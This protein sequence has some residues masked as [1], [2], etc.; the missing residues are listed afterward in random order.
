MSVMNPNNTLEVLAAPASLSRKWHAL[1]GLTL[2]GI[3][4]VVPLPCAC[5]SSMTSCGDFRLSMDRMSS[6]CPPSYSTRLSRFMKDTL[7][8]QHSASYSLIISSIEFPGLPYSPVLT[9]IAESNE[10]ARLAKSF[11]YYNKHGE[12]C[13]QGHH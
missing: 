13:V 8:Q 12:E 2:T 7:L 11:K 9:E 5:L 3:V 1:Q 10:L 6:K 4:L